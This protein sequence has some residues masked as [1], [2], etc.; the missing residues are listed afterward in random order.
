MN[1]FIS[2]FAPWSA[3]LLAFLTGAATA[4]AVVPVVFY[5]AS[6][7]FTALLVVICGLLTVPFGG[8][9]GIGLKRRFA[10]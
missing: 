2:A 10:I 9:L 4:A 5:N 3:A 6:S 8:L 7:D 1:A